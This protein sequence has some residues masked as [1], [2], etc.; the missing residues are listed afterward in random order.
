[1]SLIKLS[2]HSPN[3]LIS[4]ENVFRFTIGIQNGS[5]SLHTIT[6]IV[7]GRTAFSK[8]QFHG[9]FKEGSSFSNNLPNNGYDFVIRR[10]NGYFLENVTITVI[11]GTG[12]DGLSTN[13]YHLRSSIQR[14]PVNNTLTSSVSVGSQRAPQGSRTPLGL[15]LG[16]VPLSTFTGEGGPSVLSGATGLGF[17]SPSLNQQPGDSKIDVRSFEVTSTPSESYSPPPESNRR[18]WLWGP[19]LAI[20]PPN[21]PPFPPPYSVN[22]EPTFNSEFCFLKTTKRSVYGVLTDTFSSQSV[23]ILY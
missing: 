2:E 16:S 7:E 19:P 20:P 18:P 15:T 5:V 9:E 6:I 17:F 3:G 12:Y 11:A 10:V 1:M 8:N 22:Y 14:G 4:I 21:P 13:T 23:L